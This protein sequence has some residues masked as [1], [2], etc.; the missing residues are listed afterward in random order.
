M[1]KAFAFAGARL[2]YLAADAAVAD[3]LRLVRLPYHLSA[4]TQAAAVAALD[5]APEMLAMVD[6]IAR[7]RDRMLD[8]LPVLGYR[9][10]P[11]AANFVLFDGLDDP[12][13]TFRALLERDILIRDVGIPGA[14]RV[15]AGHRGGDH[16]LPR[17]ARCPRRLAAPAATQA[18]VVSID[19][20]A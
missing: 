2:G 16:V 15:T 8:E 13:A 20:A 18:D 11:S 1:S 7:Q 10:W 19:S 14:L 6:D 9:A 17:A 5:H 3:A 12:G 4:L